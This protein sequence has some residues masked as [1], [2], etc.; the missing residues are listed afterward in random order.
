VVSCAIWARRDIEDGN[1]ILKIPTP[2]DD[3]DADGPPEGP[4]TCHEEIEL[5][6]IHRLTASDFVLPDQ[7]R[8]FEDIFL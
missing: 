7:H 6:G 3:H 4:T 5:T 8:F 2:D 1:T